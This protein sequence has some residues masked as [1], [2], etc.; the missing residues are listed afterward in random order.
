MAE[1]DFKVYRYRWVVLAVFMF[2]NLTIQGLWI[3]Y[4]PVTGPAAKFYGVTDLQIGF[5]SMV[6]MIAFLPL[7]IPVSWLIDT[8]GFKLAVGVGV[9]LMSIFGILRGLVGQNYTLVLISTIGIAAAQPFLLN[10]WMKVAANWFALKER[11]T[12]VGL[13]TLANLVGMA[14]GMV[15][16]PM[17]IQTFSIPHIQL[18]YGGIAAFSALL[19][20]IFARENP[21]TPPCP[22]GMEARALMLDGLKQALKVKAFW[23]WLI[24]T[25]VGLGLF[26]GISTWIENIVRPRGFS[27]TDAGTLGAAI[28][29]GGV[30]GAVIL[31]ALSD[32]YQKRQLFL[33]LSIGLAIPG[34]V[35]IAYAQSLGFLLFSGVWM[36][37]FLV[38]ANPIGMQYSA[39]VTFPTPEGTLNG[40]IQL[41]GQASVVFVYIMEAFRAADGSFTFALL[42]GALSLLIC[43][44]LVTKMKDAKVAA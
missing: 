15:F 29:V 40:L 13:V 12:A 6:F 20:L 17:L 10:A 32:K 16:T 2:A 5:L 33:F 44:L 23:Y 38:G 25:F 18:A 4:A 14:L 1:L 7:S 27:P 8:Y 26:N 9:I 28:L 34:L 36:G 37:F 39:E 22:P 31:P 3:A 24:I 30:L 11:A 19:F 43:L 35:G 41:F 42:F 21:P